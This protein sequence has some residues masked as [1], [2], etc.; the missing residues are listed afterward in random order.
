MDHSMD[1]KTG[2]PTSTVYVNPRSGPEDPRVGLKGGLYDAKTAASGLEMLLTLP[3]PAG[4]D[5]DPNYVPAGPP[6]TPCTCAAAG[7]SAAGAWA[8]WLD[9]LGPGVRGQ[10]DVCGEL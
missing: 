9:E 8:V 10:D 3:K 5:P 2:S 6:G 1:Q 7:T 4:F